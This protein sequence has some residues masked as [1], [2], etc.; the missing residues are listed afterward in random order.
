MDPF[1]P[2]P[3]LFYHRLLLASLSLACGYNMDD[4]Y[5]N[6]SWAL[7]SRGLFTTLEVND[8]IVSM[9]ASLDWRLRDDGEDLGDI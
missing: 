7:A 4:S 2:P 9:L 6:A 1:L 5:S 8:M 3:A